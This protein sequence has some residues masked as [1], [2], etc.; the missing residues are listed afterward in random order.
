MMEFN[1]LG[2]KTIAIFVSAR[3]RSRAFTVDGAATHD[4]KCEK[5]EQSTIAT[6]Y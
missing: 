3:A 4:M 2:I 6:A 5:K 1:N